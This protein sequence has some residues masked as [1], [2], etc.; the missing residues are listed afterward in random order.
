[1]N[2]LEKI[3]SLFFLS[4]FFF[5]FSPPVQAKMKSGQYQLKIKEFEVVS[6]SLPDSDLLDIL[7]M[8]TSNYQSQ[9]YLVKAGFDYRQPSAPFSLTIPQTTIELDKIKPETPLIRSNSL[10]VSPGSADGYQII[11]WQDHPLQVIGGTTQI[12]DTTCNGEI[13]TCDQTAAALW[14]DNTKH[15]FGFNLQ[16]EGALKDFIN[17]NYY[18]Q[19][20]D[21]STNEQAKTIIQSNPA[22][23]E[24]Q[25]TINYKINISGIQ[26]DSNYDNIITLLAVPSY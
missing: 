18:R 11:A 8:S 15:G 12:P 23:E 21:Q 14:D 4:A 24:E 3:L 1:M 6:G 16:G 26:A 20:A 2:Q 25:T 9:G 22:P 10:T 13:E 5:Y 17:E 7:G 19:F